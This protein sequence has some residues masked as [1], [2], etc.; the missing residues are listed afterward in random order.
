MMLCS[1]GI[2]VMPGELWG[3]NVSWYGGGGFIRDRERWR[4]DEG[5][6]G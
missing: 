3:N 5:T 6:S 2:A 4:G 1:V